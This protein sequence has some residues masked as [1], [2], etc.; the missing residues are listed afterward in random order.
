MGKITGILVFPSR[1]FI[2]PSDLKKGEQIPVLLFLYCL[3]YG[4]YLL[5]YVGA[6]LSKYVFG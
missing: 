5:F 2:Y 6:V 1:S 3:Y 4:K